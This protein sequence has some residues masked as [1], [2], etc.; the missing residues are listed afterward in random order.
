MKERSFKKGD[1]LCMVGYDPDYAFMV[2]K[3]HLEFFECPE[4]GLEETLGVGSF[5]CEF[6]SFLNKK[7]LTMNVRAV[8]DTEGFEVSCK[9][10]TNFMRNNPGLMLLINNVKY[11]L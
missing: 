10:I 5:V 11:I 9:D 2:S 3:G 4:A 8:E 7:P 6:H 1:V